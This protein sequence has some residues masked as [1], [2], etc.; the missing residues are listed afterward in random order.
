MKKNRLILILGIVLTLLQTSC[1][2][3]ENEIKETDNPNPESFLT[4]ST[5]DINS[6]YPI[7]P[8][9]VE[10]YSFDSH[11]QMLD[12]TQLQSNVLK[13]ASTDQ[14]MEMCIAYP[15]LVD[16]YAY[17]DIGF[18]V[19]QVAGRFNGLTELAER[20][21]NAEKILEYLETSNSVAY[22]KST[23]S[24]KEKSRNQF[25]HK[26]AASFLMIDKVKRNLSG[27]LGK[28]AITYLVN[29]IREEKEYYGDYSHSLT[30]L[31]IASGINGS[32]IEESD[33]SKHPSEKSLIVTESDIENILNSLIQ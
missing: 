29:T 30:L 4:R 16:I 21:D 26:T 22:L 14:L 24:D 1:S 11:Q 5:L 18:G 10:W 20:P 8:G 17:D 19:N 15:L 9:S 12:A 3:S 27:D 28:R 2:V 25:Y 6:L 7:R 23:V 31:E 32:V 33:N 13:S